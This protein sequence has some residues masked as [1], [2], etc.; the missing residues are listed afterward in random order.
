MSALTRP[1][2][3]LPAR[4]YWTRRLLLLG[5]SLALV[6]VVGLAL[7]R[8]S[9]GAGAPDQ[10]IRVDAMTSPG[11]SSTTKARPPRKSKK[12]SKP[13]LAQPD[14]PC[15]ISDVDITPVMKKTTAGSDVKFRLKLSTRISAACTWRLSPQTLT[16]KV[17]SGDDEF[18]STRECSRGVP[19]RELVL[20][21]TKPVQVSMAWPARRI[22]DDCTLGE[23]ALAGWYHLSVAPLGG[24]PEDVAFEMDY[25]VADVVTASPK[26]DRDKDR[27]QGGDQ[28]GGK[29]KDK[30][31]DKPGSSDQPSRSPSGAVEPDGN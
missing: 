15:E 8:G 9:D 19:T 10:A 14:G 22:D 30:Q 27:D 23:W 31:G 25:P 2:G 16:L 4:V 24:E 3:P 7:N 21:R 29:N 11:S 17:T 12:P 20:R 1:R 13:P 6:G 28:G 5:L 18:W 26:P